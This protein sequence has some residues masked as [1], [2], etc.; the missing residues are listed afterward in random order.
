MV[1]AENRPWLSGFL[2]AAA[3]GT[4]YLGYQRTGGVLGP[5]PVWMRWAGGIAI[6]IV[7]ISLQ[8]A[9]VGWRSRSEG[10]LHDYCS[11]GA[12]SQAQ[13][14]GCLDHVNHRQIDRLDTH[15]ARFA[16]EDLSLCLSDAGPFC[17]T[18]LGWQ[19]VRDEQPPPGR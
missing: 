11:Y 10:Y 13:L 15:A 1:L 18:A 8:A 9:A 14:E 12:V 16:R 6:A 5:R 19:G 3:A 2:I 4:L 7:A 17:E